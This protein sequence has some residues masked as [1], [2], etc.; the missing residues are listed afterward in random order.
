MKRGLRI[1]LVGALA[2]FVGGGVSF[3]NASAGLVS[4]ND[5]QLRPFAPW[6]DYSY[7]K[8]APNGSFGEGANGWSLSRGARVVAD[9]NPLISGSSSLLLP[10]GSSATAPAA[11][12][13]LA[14]PASRFFFRNTGSP[15]GALQVDVTYRTLLGLFTVTSRL[16]TFTADGEWQPSPKY[17]HLVSNVLGLLALNP[18]IAAS[19]RFKFTP[20]GRGAEYQIDDLFVDPLLQI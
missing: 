14:D 6:G 16:G 15:N 13:K 8:L 2:A 18:S 10:A 11:C 1:V 9:G 7:Y 17:G 20:V 19:L 4:C 3:E 5:S 12:T